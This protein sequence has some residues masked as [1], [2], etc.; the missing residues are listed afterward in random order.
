M[1]DKK[2]R[3][4]VKSEN[5]DINL[6]VARQAVNVVNQFKVKRH[7]GITQQTNGN[8]LQITAFVS[9]ADQ[10]LIGWAANQ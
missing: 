7:F 4:G 2:A 10:I 3:E 8:L 1:T 9:E 6:K 5:D